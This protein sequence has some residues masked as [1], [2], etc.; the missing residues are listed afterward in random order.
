MVSMQNN[1]Y[2]DLF[3]HLARMM[4]EMAKKLPDTDSPKIIGCTII[5]AGSEVPPGFS[6]DESGEITYEVVE[7]KDR[8]YI[9]AVIPA[10]VRNAP[11]ADI[12][13]REVRIVTD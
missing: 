9:T 13:P 1:P 6:G 12:L 7:G 2:D 3:R 11:T 5:T 4:E 10:T 8:I